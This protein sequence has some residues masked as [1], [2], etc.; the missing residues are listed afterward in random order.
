MGNSST[1]ASVL[2]ILKLESKRE[3][4]SLA[5]TFTTAPLEGFLPQENLQFEVQRLTVPEPNMLPPLIRLALTPSFR[6]E[7]RK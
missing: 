2:E 6:I 3:K 4:I 5:T 1:G 7:N